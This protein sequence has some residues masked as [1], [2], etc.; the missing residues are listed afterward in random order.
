M[1]EYHTVVRCQR[2]YKIFEGLTAVSIKNDHQRTCN[3]M[4]PLIADDVI[5]CDMKVKLNEQLAQFRTYSFEIENDLEMKSWILTNASTLSGITGSRPELPDVELKK[6]S[7]CERELA[8][9]YTIWRTLFGNLAVPQHPCKFLH[10]L[11][12]ARS[13][14]TLPCANHL[15]VI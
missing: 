9:W 2:C 10:F 8:K 15:L 11:I 5:D 1:K 14:H 12:M 4:K 3:T 7:G 13:C 6:L